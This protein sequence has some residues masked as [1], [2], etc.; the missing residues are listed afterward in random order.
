MEK[1]K[2]YFTSMKVNA[3]TNLLKKLNHLV[4][5]AGIANIDFEN[6]YTAIK[7]HFGEPGNLAYLR[8]NYAKVIVDLVKEL[9]GKPF[10]TDCNTL[11][12]GRRKNALDHLDSAYE[13]GYNPFA[14]GCHVIHCRRLEGHRRSIG[15]GQRGIC[16]GSQNRKS[17]DGCRCIYFPDTF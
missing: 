15:A 4:R 6:K 14:T 5:E 17:R 11:Y 1:S 9:G 13:N 7:I 12:V 2:V 16:E 8:P 3:G 10:L